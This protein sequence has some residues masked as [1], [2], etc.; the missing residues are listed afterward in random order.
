MIDWSDPEAGRWVHDQ[1]RFPNLIRNGVTIHWTD[2][3]EPE[4]FNSAACYDGVET[5]NGIPKNEHPDIHNLYKLLWNR[6]IWHGYVD[7]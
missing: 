3:G 2:L 7:R 1:R 5:V 6:S 4:S